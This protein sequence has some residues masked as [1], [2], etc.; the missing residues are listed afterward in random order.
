ML[1]EIEPCS[2]LE[3]IV[4]ITGLRNCVNCIFLSVQLINST[5]RIIN[6]VAI[7]LDI[8]TYNCDFMLFFQLYIHLNFQFT[9]NILK[10]NIYIYTNYIRSHKLLLFAYF[11]I[12]GNRIHKKS[13]QKPVLSS[14][15]HYLSLHLL[16][17]EGRGGNFYLTLTESYVLTKFF[18]W[19]LILNA[20]ITFQL[21]VLSFSLWVPAPVL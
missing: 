17:W 12:Q 7:Y 2:Y 3:K 19:S 8:L 13:L 9:D 14:V 15:L 10:K 11:S 5:L 16:R 21:N 20:F 18:G 4:C 1:R 6:S